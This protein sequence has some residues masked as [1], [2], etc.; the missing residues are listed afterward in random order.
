MPTLKNNPRILHGAHSLY[1]HLLAIAEVYR[2]AGLVQI[3]NTFPS[4]LYHRVEMAGGQANPSSQQ[5]ELDLHLKTSGLE[6]CLESLLYLESPT[7]THC[8][9]CS[10]PISI[11][12]GNGE[13]YLADLALS[14]LHLLQSIPLE[15]RTRCLQPFLLVACCSQLHMPSPLSAYSSN[16][17]ASSAIESQL[18]LQAVE[19]SRMRDFLIGRL[20]AFLYVLPPKPIQVCIDIV[21]ETWRRMDRGEKEVFWVDV[22]IENGWETT[23]G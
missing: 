22:M 10:P 5:S 18:S 14:T 12:T 11:Y 2:Q 23:M 13:K 19:I 17:F 20:T 21:K 9:R 15:S 6:C 3:Y 16:A 1:R 8:Q 7:H 4:L